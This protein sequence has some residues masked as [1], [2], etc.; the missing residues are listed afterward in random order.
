MLAPAKNPE[1]APNLE[2]SFS[3][4]PMRISE[5]IRSISDS[6][7]KS[8]QTA[9]SDNPSFAKA[10]EGEKSGKVMTESGKEGKA[11]LF[12]VSPAPTAEN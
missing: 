1:T 2:E 9:E 3:R 6:I 7:N 4:P 8:Q 11:Q 10:T 12:N 5:I